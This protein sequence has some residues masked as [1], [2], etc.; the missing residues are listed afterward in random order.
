[1]KAE[2]TEMTISELSPGKKRMDGS[3]NDWIKA[4]I[5]KNMTPIYECGWEKNIETKYWLDASE[6]LVFDYIMV[7]M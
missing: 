7:M 2:A 4:M 1:M 3:A 5:R 6:M